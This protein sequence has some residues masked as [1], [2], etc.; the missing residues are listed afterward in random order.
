MGLRVSFLY[1]SLMEPSSQ[2]I[3]SNPPQIL[4]ISLT[5]ALHTVLEFLLISE[6]K[7]ALSQFSGSLV[8]KLGF[9]HEATSLDF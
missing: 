5:S 7:L 3:G 4:R 1:S 8:I 6:D 9:H 2:T